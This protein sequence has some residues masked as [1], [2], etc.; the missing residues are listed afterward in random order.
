MTA[1]AMGDGR[2]HA[3]FASPFVAASGDARGQRRCARP[4][5]AAS[6]SSGELEGLKSSAR[7]APNKHSILSDA[8]R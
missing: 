7:P 4:G 1:W 6:W 2:L 5:G 8:Q 3:A